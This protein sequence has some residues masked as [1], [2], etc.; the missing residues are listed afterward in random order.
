MPW[1]AR[2][3]GTHRRV[4]IVWPGGR[5]EALPPSWASKHKSISFSQ[6]DGFP[7]VQCSKQLS[8]KCGK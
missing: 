8:S 1:R 5:D 6:C 3:H 7:G 2:Q 4:R